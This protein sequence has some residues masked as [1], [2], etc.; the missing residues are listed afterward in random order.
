MSTPLPTGEKALA[1]LLGRLDA[2]K[3]QLTPTVA[4]MLDRLPAEM[5]PAFA[6]LF[7]TLNHAEGQLDLEEFTRWEA[8]EGDGC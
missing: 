6:A 1:W 8:E 7:D 4:L 2:G 3:T 5:R